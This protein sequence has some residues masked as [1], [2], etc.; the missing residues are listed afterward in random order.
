MDD[1]SF[2]LD[3]DKVKRGQWVYGEKCTICHGVA[4]VAGGSAPDLRASKVPLSAEAFASIVRDGALMSRGMPPFTEL[5]DD[6]LESIRHF[7][8]ERARYE[9]ERAS[10]VAQKA[11]LER[12]QRTMWTVFMG[13]FA[14]FLVLIA[15]TSIVLTHR[16]AGPLLRIR[17][18]VKD[19]AGGTIRPPPY[20]LRDKDELKDLFDLESLTAE[21][22]FSLEHYRQFFSPEAL[23]NL[24]ALWNS[25][26]ISVLSV[27]LSG[28]VGVPLAFI[29]NRYEF[30]GRSFFASAAAIA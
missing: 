20:G 25:L 10:I 17:R 28:L 5:G 13:A 21:G 27:L 1:P 11:E 2:V 15:L 19:V 8:R 22:R 29:F 6:D 12:R 26:Y 23:T 3:A 14:A 18:M 16:V 9:A 4:A 30:P 24:E 7:L